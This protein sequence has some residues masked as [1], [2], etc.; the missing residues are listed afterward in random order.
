[1]V[2][3]R[4]TRICVRDP[5]SNLREARRAY[6]A[7]KAEQVEAFLKGTAGRARHVPGLSEE[8][9]AAA[10]VKAATIRAAAEAPK[11]C[12]MHVRLANLIPKKKATKMSRHFSKVKQ[13]NAEVKAEIKEEAPEP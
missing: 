11:D 9:I 7:L 13:V 3:L 5:E 6:D 8:D 2:Q 1:M 12:R 10:R 4:S